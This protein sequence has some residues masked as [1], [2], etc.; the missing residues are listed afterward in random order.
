MTTVDPD[1]RAPAWFQRA[2]AEV[3]V[4]R[5][6]IVEGAGVH[7]RVWG[8]AGAPG[9]VLVH[10][11]A[12]HSGWWDHIAPQLSG[13]RVVAVDLSGHGDSA[14]RAEYDPLLW[15]REVVAVAA[16]EGLHHPVVVGH[17]MGGWVAVTV[18]VEH[19]DEVSSVVVIDSPLN[20]QPPD[21][22][23]L[24]ERRRPHRVYAT[25]IDAVGHFRTLPPQDVVLPYVRDHVARGSLRPVDGGWTWKFDPDFFGIRLRLRDLLPDLDRPVTLFRCEHGLVSPE[26][27]VEMTGLVP[28][29]LPVI[30]LPD[31]GHH[32]MLDQP[33][34]LVT[35]LRTLLASWP[36]GGVPPAR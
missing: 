15:A 18:G 14:R 5:E 25:E 10:G 2:L 34:A 9:V 11:G 26:M 21:E 6:V 22:R 3:P 13:H 8:P 24:R 12:A 35:G 36:A 17:S 20:D 28:A 27:A 19:A 29:A 16:A 33:L 7:Y 23:R 31:A 4:H 1:D 30:D 32:P